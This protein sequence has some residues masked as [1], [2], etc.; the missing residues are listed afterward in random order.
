[1]FK[2]TGVQTQAEQLPILLL[3]LLAQGA[4][5]PPSRETAHSVKCVHS[6]SAKMLMSIK[7]NTFPKA[8]KKY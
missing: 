7:K 2:R 1:L 5:P 6:I 3:L 8:T 4:I